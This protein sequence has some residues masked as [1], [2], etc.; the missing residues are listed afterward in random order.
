MPDIALFLAHVAQPRS[1]YGGGSLSA[2]S[3]ASAAAL[4][5]KLLSGSAAKRARAS[6]KRCVALVEKDATVFTGVVRA[7]RARK[8]A[9][10]RRALK[11]AAGVQIEIQHHAQRLVA[12]CR[13]ARPHI[14]SVYASDLSCALHLAKAASTCASGFV[15]ANT[16]WLKKTSRHG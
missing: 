14:P 1:R 15:K 3:A 4:L 5:E 11:Q 10:L 7:L 12:Q 2:L 6:R 9:A 16:A 8:T 13:S